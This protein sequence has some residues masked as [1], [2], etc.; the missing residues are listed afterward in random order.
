MNKRIDRAL[1][2]IATGLSII[3]SPL[4]LIPGFLFWGV[5]YWPN[6]DGLVESIIFGAGVFPVLLRFF[7]CQVFP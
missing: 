3:F 6:S 7:G 5:K 1:D 4:I 2:I